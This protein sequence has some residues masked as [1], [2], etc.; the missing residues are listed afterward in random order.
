[1]NNTSCS[2]SLDTD[3]QGLTCIYS[4]SFSLGLP[5]NLL[6]LWELYQIGFSGGGVQLVYLLNLLLSDLLQLLTL[7]M[8]ILVAFLCLIAVDRYLAIV[9]PLESRRV[10]TIQVAV[11]S[12]LAVWTITFLFCLSGLYPSVFHQDSQLCLEEYPV[13]ARYAGFKIATIA[14]GFLLPCGILG[15]TSVRIGVALKN[16][17]STSDR[18]RHKI[19]GTLLIITVIFIV[20]F[21][22]YHLVGSY[23][24]A[25]YF[26]TDDRCGL[27]RSL[28]LTYRLCYGLTS[29]N[30]LLDPFFYI[31]LSNNT[32]KELKA[33][34]CLRRGSRRGNSVR[35]LCLELENQNCQLLAV[36]SAVVQTRVHFCW[37]RRGTEELVL[38]LRPRTAQDRGHPPHH[39][40]HLHRRLRP[41]PPGRRLQVY[42]VLPDR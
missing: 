23:K 12:S 28:Y 10:R 20:V 41:L 15:Y 6:S 27:E 34:V 35:D 29:L 1:M 25:E 16:S 21:G 18:E 31:F 42:G 38:H 17:S 4:L 30:N 13:S 11:L 9:L 32:R 2:L 39:H 37:H 3:I 33:L 36:A 5:A 40:R 14:L 22:P 26:L 24:F 7:P 8:W 19:V